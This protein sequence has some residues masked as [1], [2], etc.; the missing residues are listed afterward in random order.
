[1]A[2]L[3]IELN[4]GYANTPLASY[5]STKWNL[6]TM[7]K[8][9]TDLAGGAFMAPILPANFRP[10]ETSAA[11]PGI[12]PDGVQWSSTLDWSF[13]FDNAATAATRRIQLFTFD[14][15]SL[16]LPTF[17]GFITVTFPW[18]TNCT[19]QGAKVNYNLYTVG[20]ASVSG[21]TVTGTSTLW[22]TNRM[23]VG[24]RIVFGTTDPTAYTAANS[25]VITNIG[26]EGTITIADNLGTIGVGVYV[27]ED[28]QM[29]LN[30]RNT[31]T[32]NGG[33]FVIKGLSYRDFV[34]GG[35]AVPAAT[36]VDNIKA[37][38][39][40]ADAT[41]VTNI[42]GI[43]I[44]QEA[45][46]NWTTQYVYIGD[47]AATTNITI[48][49]YN[50]RVA[51]TNLS[52]GKDFTSAVLTAKTGSQ[53]GLTGNC[54]IV[55]NIELATPVAGHGT[56]NGVAA[57]F[58]NTVSR[59]YRIP[60]SGI[61]GASTTFVTDGTTEVPVGGVN[62]FAATGALAFC[63]YVPTLDA[64]IINTSAATGFRAYVS[65]Y[66]ADG[67]RFWKIFLTDDKQLDQQS[68]YSEGGIIHGTTQ[69]VLQTMGICGGLLYM[70]G[71]GTTAITNIGRILP[72][73]SDALFQ[74]ASLTSGGTISATAQVAI[75]P[76]FSLVAGQVLSTISAV[77]MTQMGHLTSEG[78]GVPTEAIYL[79]Y[80]TSGID[81]NTGSWLPVPV[82]GAVSSVSGPLDC[83][84]AILWR[85][86]GLSCVPERVYQLTATYS[87]FASHP[88]F[89]ISVS[90]SDKTLK[91]FGFWQDTAFGGTAMPVMRAMAFDRDNGNTLFD[92]NSGTGAT[93]SWV[94]SVDAGVSWGAIG[95]MDKV[96]SRTV[97]LYIP[98]SMSDNVNA[99]FKIGTL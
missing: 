57:L 76:K 69:N 87:D 14:R 91:R 20:T 51:L 53:T 26:A 59:W 79:F 55:D 89:S 4:Q 75:S 39:W 18:A 81:N 47:S 77:T 98:S 74:I 84:L 73:G 11:I 96:G 71:T 1:M 44:D 27:I 15:T 34:M 92:D 86:V 61:V 16:A 90:N 78:L 62:V 85:T 37:C 23:S 52:S 31:T 21:T 22:Q 95:T 32:T 25:S 10:V 38:Y 6:G 88:Y 43:G 65:K 17:I 70:L 97:F 72:I 42:T 49:K 66:Y 24:S 41:T 94:R 82:N 67:T 29:N 58:F 48:Y 12:L 80:R 54:A 93:G 46:T 28:L 36:T 33:F 40:L 56:G 19:I 2:I 8:K 68:A 64:F 7:I 3:G 99:R 5:D 9:R 60:T 35:S 50:C 45:I 83:Q 63:K 30:L 13:S